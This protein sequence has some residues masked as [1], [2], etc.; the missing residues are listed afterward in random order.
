NASCRPQYT[1]GSS[2][3]G[4]ATWFALPGSHRTNN[5]KMRPSSVYK[6][7]RSPGHAMVTQ[8][9]DIQKWR[10][11]SL[12]RRSLGFLSFHEPDFGDLASTAISTEPRFSKPTESEFSKRRRTRKIELDRAERQLLL[13]EGM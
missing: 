5:S 4:Q 7:E 9:C 6:E 10:S 12:L 13:D 1:G 11:S 8:F 2:V 3:L